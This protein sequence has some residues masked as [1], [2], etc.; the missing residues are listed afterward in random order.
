MAWYKAGI[1]DVKDITE[2]AQT[3]FANEVDQVFRVEPAMFE[4]NLSLAIVNQQYNPYST[5]VLVERADDNR[6]R[7]YTW[8][9]R[10]ERAVWSSEEMVTI[11]MA[12]VDL[13][14]TARER[15][16]RVKE[17]MGYWEVWAIECGVPIVCST[18]M[19][20]DQKGFLNLHE[21]MGYSVRGSIGYKRLR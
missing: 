19:R 7:A 16:Q 15:V 3:N 12:H 9:A 8:A 2:L 5:L 13:T 10:G 1:E 14:D 20:Y 4:Y 21:R 11:R 18:T 17:M 6:V